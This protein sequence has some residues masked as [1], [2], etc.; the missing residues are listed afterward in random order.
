MALGTQGGRGRLWVSIAKERI[1]SWRNSACLCMNTTGSDSCRL[2]S[3]VAALW[4]MI[5][6]IAVSGCVNF[7]GGGSARVT[8]GYAITP[9]RAEFI[10]TGVT[11]R[12]QVLMEFGGRLNPPHWTWLGGRR[13]A[14]RWTTS[15]GVI[16]GVMGAA[17]PSVATFWV[18]QSEHAYC[19][20]FDENDPV[21]RTEFFKAPDEAVLRSQ[22]ERWLETPPSNSSANLA[23]R[24]P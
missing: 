7:G 17:D 12:N 2:R 10:S 20:V 18:Q 15:N 23:S 3:A 1:E 9:D 21:V 5:S 13:I 11:T 16:G 6:S 8:S 14:Y 19:V 22:V 4:L 24:R